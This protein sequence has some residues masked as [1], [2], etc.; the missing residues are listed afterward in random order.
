M[1]RATASIKFRTQ[2][3]WSISNGFG[4]IHS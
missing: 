2:V 3:S 1:R 4:A